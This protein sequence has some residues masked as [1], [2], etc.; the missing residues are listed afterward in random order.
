MPPARRQ[1]STRNARGAG[2][3]KRGYR[4]H[5]CMW[6]NVKMGSYGHTRGQ[7]VNEYLTMNQ[8]WDQ[9]I[10]SVSMEDGFPLPEGWTIGLFS[11]RKLL[12][13][14]DDRIDTLFDGGNT[15]TVKVFDE[16]DRERV[17][18]GFEGWGFHEPG[19]RR[20]RWVDTLE[21][22]NRPLYGL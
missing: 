1:W 7:D 4:D 14:T 12:P 8:L 9:I 11:N 21:A 10:S 22:M 19:R 6:I 15:V 18:D 16:E 2:W 17:Y 3:H 13:Q 5:G 20:P